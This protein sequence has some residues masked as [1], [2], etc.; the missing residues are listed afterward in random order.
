MAAAL[1]RPPAGRARGGLRLGLTLVLGLVVAAVLLAALR[2]VGLLG[3]LSN[4]FASTTVDRSGP[5]VMKALEDLDQY[6]GA[7]ANYEQIIEIE[8]DYKYVPSFV[9]GERTL[10]TAAGSVDG[11][12]DFDKIGSGAVTVSED[13][14]SVTVTLPHATR[15]EP[16]LDAERSRVVSRER[17]VIDRSLSAFDDGGN[18]S[19]FYGLG[20]R[21]LAEAA[22]ADQDLL[23]RTEEN[24]R[25]MLSGLIKALGYE[26]VTVT[27]T[28]PSGAPAL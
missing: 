19:E 13:G 22:A 24:T 12:V 10:F 14:R 20:Q 15:G 23:P 4:P 27:F 7:R 6:T 3:G 28:E 2:G 17:G 5:A 9:R 26:Q 11:I 25:Q 18:D 8:K 21:K 16:R 1:L